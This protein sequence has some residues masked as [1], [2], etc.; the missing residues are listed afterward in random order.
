MP[1]TVL[2]HLP[3]CRNGDCPT[4]FR[5]DET[6]LIGIQGSVAPGAEKEHISWMTEDH[7]RTLSGQLPAR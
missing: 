2:A 6:G 7:F 4:I 1:W 5:D 3:G